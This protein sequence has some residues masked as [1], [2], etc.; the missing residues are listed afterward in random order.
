M[1]RFR[2]I[3][4]SAAG[5]EPIETVHLH[6]RAF[7]TADAPVAKPDRVLRRKRSHALAPHTPPRGRD[8]AGVWGMRRTAYAVG[9]LGSRSRVRRA[10]CAS[11]GPSSARSA[12]RSRATSTHR[13]A[14]PVS[15]QP[16]PRERLVTNGRPSPGP[17]SSANG[18]PSRS[19]S[20]RPPERSL[21]VPCGPVAALRLSAFPPV[22]PE[23]AGPQRDPEPLGASD[24]R[25]HPCAAGRDADPHG[26]GGG[27][28]LGARALSCR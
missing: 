19:A 12:R 22:S 7:A 10:W 28:L 14:D 6:A 26:G 5:A 25:S 27:K 2:R 23:D 16:A 24:V 17:R 8:G 9:R 3:L 13:R 18:H 20:A 1:A 21:R 11:R 4:L 15:E